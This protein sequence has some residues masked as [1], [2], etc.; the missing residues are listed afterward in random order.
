MRDDVAQNVS[1]RHDI[2]GPVSAEKL[3]RKMVSQAWHVTARV[4]AH[5]RM[6]TLRFGSSA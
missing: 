1:P 3:K 2:H 5:M 6:D 4:R